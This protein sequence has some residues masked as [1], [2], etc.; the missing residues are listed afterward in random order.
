MSEHGLDYVVM[1][2]PVDPQVAATLDAASGMTQASAADRAT[3]AWQFD[4]AAPDDAIDGEGPWWH[5][6][7]LGLQGLAI[8]VIVV[9]CGPTRRELR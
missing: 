1:P 5:P 3:R 2:A 4:E 7:L 8:L 6:W 9:L